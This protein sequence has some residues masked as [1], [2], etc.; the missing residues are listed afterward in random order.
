MRIEGGVIKVG[1]EK[2]KCKKTKL[3]FANVTLFEYWKC[4]M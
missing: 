1:D 4:K 2:L 3:S